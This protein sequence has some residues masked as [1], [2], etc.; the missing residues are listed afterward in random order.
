MPR[1]SYRA[2]Y[3]ERL[4][5]ACCVDL[6][7]RS[8]PHP[9]CNLCHQPVLPGD[10]W[11]VSHSGAPKANG[12]K[13]VGVAHRNCNQRDGH[14]NVTPMVAK[15]KRQRRRHTGVTG[16]GLGPQPMRCGKRSA[17]SRT[18]SHGVVPRRNHAA[19]HRIAMA[20]RYFTE[21]RT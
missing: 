16:P 8:S 14:E 12:G 19:K 3:R 20:Q 21:R 2:R 9:Y 17:L 13:S 7:G 1:Q 4:F 18:F 11:D 10:A 6:D 15:A 5:N